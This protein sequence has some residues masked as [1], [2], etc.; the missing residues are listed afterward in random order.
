MPARQRLVSMKKVFEKN[1]H[2]LSDI[3]EMDRVNIENRLSIK[4]ARLALKAV[5]EEF[6]KGNLKLA[7]RCWNEA[8]FYVFKLL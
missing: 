3:S 7:L 1:K 6:R 8:W 4:F 5:K 2:L